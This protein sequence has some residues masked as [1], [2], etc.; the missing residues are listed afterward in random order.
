MIE[1]AWPQAHGPV[2]TRSGTKK[3]LPAPWQRSWTHGLEF[4]LRQTLFEVLVAAHEFVPHG[5]DGLEQARVEELGKVV[6]RQPGAA[7]AAYE[8]GEQAGYAE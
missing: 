4:R 6:G 7:A 3:P 1:S 8:S 2:S 5:P